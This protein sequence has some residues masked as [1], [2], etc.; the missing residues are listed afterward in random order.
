MKKCVNN[1]CQ[2]IIEDKAEFCTNC[3]T[4]CTATSNSVFEENDFTESIDDKHRK[5]K[6]PFQF[7][8]SK[9]INYRLPLHFEINMARIMNEK[10]YC[11]LDFKVENTG[12]N[13]IKNL[14]IKISSRNF[15]DDCV[16]DD[17][18]Q[19]QINPRETLNIK[20]D[21]FPQHSGELAVKIEWSYQDD[22]YEYSPFKKVFLKVNSKN[23]HNI[24]NIQGHNVGD[25]NIS[26]DDERTE[27]EKWEI[28][29]PDDSKKK[30]LQPIISCSECS[31]AAFPIN[32]L[33]TTSQK[34]CLYTIFSKKEIILGRKKEC[35][36][37]F[38]YPKNKNIAPQLVQRFKSFSGKHCTLIC[39]DKEFII[40]DG[41]DNYGSWKN[42]SNGSY[43]DDKHLCN[44]QE[45]KLY[46]NNKF[47]VADN[48]ATFLVRTQKEN[49]V[50]DCLNYIFPKYKKS[51]IN[52][53]N[54]LIVSNY[55][56]PLPE[57]A[58][59][60]LKKFN[61]NIVIEWLN[62]KVEKAICRH[63]VAENA[64]EKIGKIKTGSL[65]SVT[66]G[67]LIEGHNYK[68]EFFK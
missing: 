27:I 44:G 35:D 6:S 2:A 32:M 23:T 20:S 33:I 62:E 47:I 22:K 50:L 14:K 53:V 68:I 15:N 66:E 42:S 34:C 60:K 55:Y 5:T 51:L 49:L 43:V 28:L 17:Y 40:K 11:P 52:L 36:F 13:K 56:F 25:I 10:E 63:T 4:A 19:K 30:K 67:L 57:N 65:I 21:F 46:N 31:A 1:K 64:T 37:C 38:D 18:S 48:N 61:N 12:S 59:L 45:L 26:K 54:E 8:K 29:E 24:I 3:G 16:I 7:I 41:A 58:E 9:I 39:D